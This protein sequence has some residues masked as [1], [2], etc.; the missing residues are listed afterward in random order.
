MASRTPFDDKSTDSSSATAAP[1][2][3]TSRSTPDVQS[4]PHE[5][6]SSTRPA[7]PKELDSIEKEKRPNVESPSASKPAQSKPSRKLHSHPSITDVRFS[8][9]RAGCGECG[10]SPLDLQFL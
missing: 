4:T 1:Q 9:L 3:L 2:E 8:P 6:N 5:T 10:V 7:E